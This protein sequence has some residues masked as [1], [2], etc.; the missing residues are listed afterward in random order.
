MKHITKV[1]VSA[2]IKEYRREH[3]LT[4]EKFGELLGVSAQAI[5]KWEREECFPDI[6]FLPEI[7]FLLQCSVND[8]FTQELL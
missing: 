5:S 3:G 2:K 6:T 8:L 1:I 7:A 4:Q